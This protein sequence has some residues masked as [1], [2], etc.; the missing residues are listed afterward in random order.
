MSEPFLIKHLD[1][2]TLAAHPQN[3]R[4]HPDPQKLALSSSLEEHGWLS[5]PIFNERTGRLLDGHAR[6]EWARD[7]GEAT[8]PVRVVDISE[9]QERRILRAFDRIGEMALIDTEALDTLLMD[10]GDPDLERLLADAAGSVV[11]SPEEFP[12]YDESIDTEHQ[13][14]KCGYQWS[15]KAA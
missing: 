15:G 12:E 8:I 6:V 10:I 1:P 9:R 4:R 11:A 14:P 5:A 7:Q 2:A 13:C 3:F